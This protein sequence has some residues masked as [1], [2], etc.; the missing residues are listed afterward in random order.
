MK[1]SKYYFLQL[2]TLALVMLL[3]A[4]GWAQKYDKF[5]TKVND[6]Y[7]IGDYVKSAKDNKK[8]F[9]KVTKKLGKE[10]N[11]VV[12]Y[13]LLAARN[14][15]A[16]GELVDFNL[17][18]AQAIE[19]SNRI[20][21]ANSPEHV[22]VLNRVA[23]MLLQNGNPKKAEEYI[24]KAR[25]A[26]EQLEENDDIK[27]YTDVNTAY[28]YATMGFYTEAIEFIEE[29]EKYYAGR[30]MPTETK[31]DPKTGKLKSIKLDKKVLEKRQNAYARLLNLKAY[32]YRHKGDFAKADE[33]FLKGADWI[34]DNLGKADIQYVRNILWQGQ[35]LEENGLDPKVVRK[36]YEDALSALK[37]NHNESH[38]LALEIYESLL[39]SYLY[40]NEMAR[41]KNLNSEYERV[42]KKYFDKNSINYVKLDAMNFRARLD[43]DKTKNIEQK[44]QEIL[45]LEIIPEYHKVRINLLNFAYE[46]ALINRTYVNADA[47]L[48]DILKQKAVLYGEESPEYHLTVT[49]TANFYVDFTDKIDAAGEIYQTSFDAIVAP[50][51]SAGHISYVRTLNHRAQYYQVSDQ[52]ELASEALTKALAATRI[53][54]DNKDI[55]YGIELDHIAALQIKIGE[56]K[57]AT[58]NIEEAL[59]ILKE[60]RRNEYRVI[61]YVEAL[62]TSAK[63]MALKGEFEDS[64]DIIKQSQKY[65]KRADDLT[66]YDELASVI[67]LA[68]V[69]V[70][71][72]RVSD[73]EAL[74]NMAVN[75]YE[76]LFGANSR[77][78][79][80][81]LLSYG[82]LKLFTGE[83]TEAERYT[84]RAM[85]IA[86]SRFGENSSKSAKGNLLLAKIYTT[87]GDYEKAQQNIEEALAI[88]ENVFGRNHIEFAKSQSQLG[89][90]MFYNNEEPDKI[91]QVFEE[92]KTTIADKL[93]NR[94]PLYA[95]V[96]KE[97][98]LLYIQEEKF[99]DAF[100]ALALSETIWETR[101]KAR[102]NVNVASIYTLTGDVYYQQKNYEM[103]ESKYIQAVALYEN[104]FNPEHPEYV[105]VISKL[106][107][108]Y[109]MQGDKRR[110]KKSL[111]EVVDKYDYFIKAY[112]PALSEREKAKYWN[113]IKSDY[114]FYVTMAMTFK[115]EDPEMIENVFNNAL[116]TKAILL[117]SAI[118]IRERILNGNDE[119]LKT[120]YS[121]W[122]V[123]K[124]LLT[125]ALSMSY[126][127]L[128]ANE[129]NVLDLQNEVEL[130]E[131]S[132]SE[133]SELIKS[134]NDQRIITWEEVQS[135]LQEN[136]VAIEMV[137]YRYFDHVF[138]DSV[139]Y[140]GLYVKNSKIQKKPDVFTLNN[141]EE[142]EGKF[143][144]A[145]R[146]SI[147]YRRQDRFSNDQYWQP[148]A[149]VVGPTA[150]IYLSADGVYNQINLEAIPISDT[151][152]VLDNSN[153][154]L[155]S[156]TKDI[157]LNSLKEPASKNINASMFGNPIYYL[158][159]SADTKRTIGQLQGTE[160][161]IN[162][163]NELLA[164]KG[165]TTST[166]METSATEAAIKSV[167]S[168]EIIH[169]ATHGFFVP[170]QKI[171][172]G[173]LADQNEAKMAENPLLRTGLLM[174]GAGDLLNKT[175]YNYN[176]ED[177]ILT[178]YEAMSMNLDQTDLVVLSA[179]ETGLGDLT[180]G[181]GVYGLQRAF[182]V[183]GA[184]TLIMSM[185]KVNDEATQKLMINFYQKWLATGNK[186]ESFVQAKKELRNEFK[187]PIYWGAFIMIGLE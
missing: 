32:A 71:Y 130:I 54:Y 56:Y 131:K 35:M 31:I 83:Y 70:K 127:Q 138:T 102:K 87:I 20:N 79:V 3:N 22:M 165:W 81:P 105:R 43:A 74:L 64:R 119:E 113:T 2:I 180:V 47:Y 90:V 88:Q 125:T 170:E 23:E 149:D 136:E 91:E 19:I 5:V 186:R 82:S 172:Q 38:F 69:Y 45:N 30:T 4:S 167:S 96:L 142:L 7:A 21:E 25:E 28:I 59:A 18:Y 181:E 66:Q 161:E 67:D 14:E 24:A 144:K 164:D 147:I 86:Q 97:I 92:A 135:V 36:T 140:A 171:N 9:K 41:F 8:L 100:N 40:N 94:T 168:P 173:A 115:D 46:A 85:E 60:E 155:V 101:L 29:N 65:F 44:V 11:Y 62:E 77:K 75:E 160:I 57:K 37:R 185:F 176:I 179:C 109:Y 72:G 128:E 39:N 49:E 78:L 63:L 76:R 163:V 106:A 116:T 132:L 158:E 126:E 16:T 34:D 48:S 104:F 15:L 154:I 174:A 150:T 108:V 61:H 152:Y 111:Q 52:L 123:K 187:D 114:E 177:G 26:V 110:A 84:R 98:S 107:K 139:I 178:A 27:A 112:F 182:M 12:E 93:G 103:A 162:E 99:D 137:R 50:Q 148:I 51:I 55:K 118:K 120:L 6:A 129:I 1:N 17:N 151:E 13:Y 80:Q 73:T 89:L 153:I 156:N 143:F 10:N 95:D 42:I 159:A 68:D 124:E 134:A 122:L 146:N 183:A 58:E 166:K 157:Y 145:Y 175:K 141:G 169:I 133:K 117:S 33:T 53:K 184:K 121:E